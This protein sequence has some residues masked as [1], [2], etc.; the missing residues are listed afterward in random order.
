V[1]VAD[2]Q[3]NVIDALQFLLKASGIGADR[4]ASPEEVLSKV[5]NGRYDLL[6][7]DMNYARDTTSGEEGLEL[8][9]QVK[10]ADPAL[11]IVVMTAWSTIEIAVA[12]LQ[13]GAADFIQKPW[14]N[15]AA[16]RVIDAQIAAC[17]K[18]RQEMSLH[19]AEA[20]EAAQVHRSLLGAS[21][22]RFGRISIAA[23]TRSHR[24]VGGDYFDFL[25]VNDDR[26]AIAIA[27]IM[28]KGIGA[29][30]LMANL[31]AHFRTHAQRAQS[32]AEICDSLNAMLLQT[33]GGRLATM[34]AA[35][36][37]IS[38]QV[39]TFC[40]AGHPEAICV[41]ADG[42]IASLTSDGPVMGSFATARYSNANRQLQHGDRIVMVTDG[43]LEAEGTAGEELGE[44]RLGGWSVELR[45][46]PADEMF[47]RLND[48][49][50]AFSGGKL[51]DDS[52]LMVIATD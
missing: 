13:H 36:L 3:P 1:L 28:G 33:S 4:A 21:S 26:V 19:R 42:T 50:L 51:S 16:L 20:E 17:K 31:Q 41:N 14:D 8:L 35:Q 11:S 22:A 5:G 29:A 7:M 34:I 47:A 9:H 12:S 45:A 48:R 43:F 44:S 32:P 6:L 23:G 10:S 37:D 15:D 24:E 18:R 27:D 2:D 46:L 52:T 39:F 40:T 25:A 38:T 30:L 49:L